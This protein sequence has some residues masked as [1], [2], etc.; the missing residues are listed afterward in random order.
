MQLASI[1]RFALAPLLALGV[2]ASC[3]SSTPE[4]HALIAGLPVPSG[5]S[6]VLSKQLDG[7]PKR[8][9]LYFVVNGAYPSAT[10]MEAFRRHFEKTGWK[11]CQGTMSTWNSFVDKSSNLAVRVHQIASIWVSL[12]NKAFA[13]VVGRY[14]SRSE[15]PIDKPDNDEQRWTVVIHTEVNATLEAK[16]LG[17][18]CSEA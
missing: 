8:Q 7:N 17:Y 10:P 16:E 5:A 4:R 14:I 11:H 1:F 12:D 2:L 9:Q 18:A 6:Q 15:A 13:F 3:T